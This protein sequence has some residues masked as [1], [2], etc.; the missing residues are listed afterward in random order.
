MVGTW[1]RTLD[2]LFIRKTD[3]WRDTDVIQGPGPFGITQDALRLSDHAPVVGT[4]ELR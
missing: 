3:T 1:N 2:Y 4:W